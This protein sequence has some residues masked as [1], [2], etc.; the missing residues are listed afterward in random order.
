VGLA[1]EHMF[2]ELAHQRALLGEVGFTQHP[3]VQ[4]DLGLVVELAIARDIHRGRQI[5][6]HVEQRV[7]HTVAIA[8]H[9]H[10]EIAGSH[11]FK[12]G[13]GRQDALCDVKSDFAPL[14]DHPSRVIFV[15]LVD[16]AVYQFKAEPFRSTT[17]GTAGLKALARLVLARDTR[18]DSERNKVSHDRLTTAL[19]V[20]QDVRAADRLDTEPS[21]AARWNETEEERAAI[22]EHDGKIPRAWAEGFARLD[23]DRPPGDV[24]TK[25]WLRFVDDTGRFLDSPFCAVAA[26]LG[27]GPCG[28]FGCN[29]DRPFAQ[30]DCAGLLWLLNGDR[31]IALS[32]NTARI[33]TRTGKR[34]SWRRKP[35]LPGR[36]LAWELAP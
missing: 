18:R 14:I 35:N 23:P 16:V 30:I 4:I 19:P 6:L 29:R 15:G 10:A 5:P 34:R 31:L 33:E 1:V 25:R 2:F 7:D 9:D 32:E 3:I 24:P 26:A 28:L 36:V 22:V 27:W 21:A 12:P 20:G 11:R 8:V 17:S 13:T